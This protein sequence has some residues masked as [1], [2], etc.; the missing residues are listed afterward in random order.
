MWSTFHTLVCVLANV[1]CFVYTR[2]EL[3]LAPT[4]LSIHAIA[5]INVY[6]DSYKLTNVAY[7]SQ[8]TPTLA[9]GSSCL[10]VRIQ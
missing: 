2:A 5:D 3:Q 8:G 9:F 10:L 7:D 4:G 1:A 6:D